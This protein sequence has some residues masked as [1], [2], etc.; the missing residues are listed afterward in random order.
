MPASVGL[1]QITVF[2]ENRAGRLAAICKALGE[3][4]VNIL[5]LSL[6][7]TADF[8]ILRIVVSDPEKGIAALKSKGFAVAVTEIVAVDVPDEPGGLGKVLHV[9][10]EAGVNVEYL[11][12]FAGER[13]G[14]A[15]IVFRFDDL[16]EAVRALKQAGINVPYHGSSG[17][18]VEG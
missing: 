16:G 1:K 4:E 5:A 10:E 2:L 9:L 6:A 7:D 18:R 13:E 3:R 17:D 15:S 12:P 8:G 14:Y 11:Y